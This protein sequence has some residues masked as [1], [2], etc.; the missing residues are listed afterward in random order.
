[1]KVII[2]E[3]SEELNAAFPAMTGY[4]ACCEL[5]TCMWAQGATPE[6]AKARFLDAYGNMP[7]TYEFA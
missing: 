2:T 7:F 4:V 3:V 5:L 6:E 1:M